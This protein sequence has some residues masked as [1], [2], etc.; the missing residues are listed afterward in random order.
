[1]KKNKDVWSV[2]YNSHFGGP[3]KQLLFIITPLALTGCIIEEGSDNNYP[4]ENSG[5]KK[6]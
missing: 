2:L 4:K 1:M 3:M 6:M 5:H